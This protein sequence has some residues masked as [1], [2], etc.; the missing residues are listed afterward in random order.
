MTTDRPHLPYPKPKPQTLTPN[1]KQRDASLALAFPKPP[2][3]ARTAYLVFC[4]KHRSAEMSWVRPGE[5]AKFTREEMQGVTTK[6]A[7]LWQKISDEELAECKQRADLL[8]REYDVAKAQMPPGALKRHKGKKK[9]ALVLV[10]GRGE[11]PKRARTAYLIF[12]DRY[13][14]AIMKDVHPDPTSKFT[15]E[16]MQQVTTRLAEMW[17]GVDTR[18]LD[19][20]K[21]EAELCKDEYKKLKEAYVP[22]VYAAKGKH[23]KKGRELN[24]GK[25]KRP[26]TAYLLFA[27]DCR[28][29][30]KKSSPDLSFTEV[31]V[32]HL[33][34]LASLITALYGVQSESTTHSV[35][36]FQS[37]KHDTRD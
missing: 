20:C 9:H 1:P 32:S 25:P 2:K 4:D 13:R 15:R 3:R 31:R 6:L 7:S 14:G 24:G 30:L 37:L 33:T 5:G 17:K 27:E 23:G 35:Y 21:L 34:R 8:K 29:R 12:C 18:E 10:E 16:E 19:Q 22:P 11:K 28:A 36:P 26:R